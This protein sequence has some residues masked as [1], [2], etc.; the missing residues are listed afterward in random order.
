MATATNS[1]PDPNEHPSYVPD[2]ETMTVPQAVRALSHAETHLNLNV[3][4][5]SA[6]E[7]W[8]DMREAV[9]IIQSLRLLVLYTMGRH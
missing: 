9:E 1:T 5:C 4:K 7:D 2:G 8:R 3:R 6:H